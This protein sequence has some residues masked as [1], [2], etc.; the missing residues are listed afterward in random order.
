MD[1]A[2]PPLKALT[3]FE[4]TVRLGSMTAAARELGTTQPAVSQRI[5]Q[6]EETVGLPL[7]ERARGR[8]QPTADGRAYHDD[9]AG[10]LRRI[11]GATQ[12][13]R[14]RARAQTRELTIAV[15]FG[16]AHLWLL[17]RL[18][19]LEAAFPGTAFEVIPVDTERGAEMADADLTIRFGVFAEGTDRERPLMPETVFPVASPALVRRHGLDG[20][21]SADA[22]GEVPLLHMDS[23]DPRWLDWSRWCEL[24]G[25]APPAGAARFHHKNY[26][27]LLNAAVEGNGLALGWQGL[28]DAL[29]DEGTLVRLGPEVAR[30]ERGYLLGARQPDA[31]V[32]APIV[33]WFVRECGGGDAQG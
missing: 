29:T 14:A 3:A 19:R 9:V 32:I 6:L 2:H 23:G 21:V 28:V 26:P 15:H 18:P 33:D 17:P 31:A 20:E 12:R 30:P 16:F 13:L 4:A 11:H 25:L 24:A 5:R 22:L 8:L 10:A 1:E 7:F 27:L